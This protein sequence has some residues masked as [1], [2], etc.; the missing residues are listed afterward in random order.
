VDV[1]EV[2]QRAFIAAYTG[3]GEF[4]VVTNFSAWL[5]SIAK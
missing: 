4:E 5:F 3:L 1:D 2:A